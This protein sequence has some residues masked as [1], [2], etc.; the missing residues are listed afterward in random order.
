MFI[1]LFRPADADQIAHL[2]HDTIRT[3]NLGYYS[4]EQVEA[5]APDDL[6]F[7]DWQTA[8]AE[9]FTYVAEED[10]QILGFGELEKDGHINCFYCH[11]DHQ[12]RGVGSQIYQAIER[13]ANLLELDFLFV[14]ASIIA[15]PF[16]QK[17]GFSIIRRQQ[18]YRRGQTLINYSM[19]KSLPAAIANKKSPCDKKEDLLQ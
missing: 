19:R 3:I 5:W 1:R 7:R 2:F 13:Q 4:P 16:F 14:E 11:K 15:K 8:C 17:M 18:V 12:R 9:C 6:Y 10:G